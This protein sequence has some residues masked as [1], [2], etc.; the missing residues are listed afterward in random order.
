MFRAAGSTKCGYAE[1]GVCLDSINF[2]VLKQVY[3]SKN[4]ADKDTI[5]RLFEQSYRL[6][7]I[8]YDSEKIGL[9]DILFDWGS[10]FIFFQIRVLFLCETT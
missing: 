1:R 2:I 8:I 3:L 4:S 10:S 6:A 7:Q 9:N 5:V